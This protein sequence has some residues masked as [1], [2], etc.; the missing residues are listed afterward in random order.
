MPFPNLLSLLAS[1]V[2]F[3]HRARTY[4]VE[5]VDPAIIL[6]QKLSNAW[7]REPRQKDI[8]DSIVEV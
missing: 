6:I 3:R 7:D 2:E 8:E 4:S 5:T 1:Q